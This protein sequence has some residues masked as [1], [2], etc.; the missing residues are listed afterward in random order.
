VFAE[1]VR[2]RL[3]SSRPVASHVSGGVD[4]ASVASVAAHL[5]QRDPAIPPIELVTLTFPGLSCDEEAFSRTVADR[6]QLPYNARSALGAAVNDP[7]RAGLFPDTYY[8]PTVM[9]MA[10]LFDMARERGI[11]TTLTGFGS[12][13]LMHRAELDQ[14]ADHLRRG[15]LT[16]V[17]RPFYPNDLPR[18]RTLL[19]V[20]ASALLPAGVRHGLRRARQ[21][22]RSVP[23]WMSET[24]ARDVRAHLVEDV[25]VRDRVPY[26]SRVAQHF[27]EWLTL[28]RDVGLGLPVCERLAARL[29]G[30]LR[31]P[32]FDVRLVELV[33]GFPQTERAAMRAQLPKP[34]LR[35]SVRGLLPKEIHDRE[36]G[37]EFTPYLERTL[38]DEQQTGVEELLHDS[39]H[40]AHG[41][42]ITEEVRMVMAGRDV[43]AI[44]ALAGMEC[45]LRDLEKVKCNPHVDPRHPSA[46]RSER[47]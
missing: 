7:L 45:W 24:L 29:G 31:H 19:T 34:L 14:L 17:L 36:E 20:G 21:S 33:L 30:E 5:R 3:R 43:T 26:P 32:F 6:W 15:E 10:L 44:C 8:R 38:L 2:C 42:V 23:R 35:R 28:N 25:T 46:E 27:C 37:A 11:R 4:S 41:Q 18:F 47:R 16:Q 1:A 13:Q 40:A 12:D 22:R 39:R 9:M